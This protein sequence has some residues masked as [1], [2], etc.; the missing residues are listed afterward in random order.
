MKTIKHN[1]PLLG[2]QESKAINDVMKSE[3]IIADSEVRKFEKSV[4]KM[5]KFK[6]AVA[7]NSGTA[8]IHLALLSLGVKESDEVILP[9]FT[10]A[11]PL[12]AI[13]YTGVKAVLVDVEKN[14]FDIDVD[15]IKRKI[16]NKT[17]AIIVPH[18]LG[19]FAKIDE[20][21]K[22]GIPIINDCAQS[23]GGIYKGKP[24]GS[25][26]DLTIFSFYAT[27]L[28]TTGQGGMVLTNNKNRAKFMRDTIDYNGR[29]NYKVRFNYP[30]TDISAA[31]GNAQLK[32]LNDFIKRRREIAK[33]YKSAITNKEISTFPN[34]DENYSNFYRFVL[35]FKSQKKRDEAKKIFIKNKIT[36]IVPI[37]EYELLYNCIGENKN[38]YPN[39]LEM[40]N[41][42]LSVPIYPALKDSEIK[43]IIETLKSL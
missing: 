2:T 42:C 7:V 43:K 3:W 9:A 8:A 28:I 24:I 33:R 32:K 27:K 5:N 15:Q 30:M 1:K 23:I 12:N 16:T 11:D 40:A 20:L 17:K 13:N 10:V 25:Y 19:S 14:S 26:G 41:T 18:M 31:M 29:T 22:I 36:A 35:K 34:L 39:S 4:A 21:E 38:D 6:Y 37:K